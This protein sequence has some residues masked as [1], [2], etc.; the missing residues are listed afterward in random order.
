[1][2]EEGVFSVDTVEIIVNNSYKD[3]TIKIGASLPRALREGLTGM[4][5]KCHDTFTWTL[6]DMTG[7][8]R[9]VIEHHLNIDPSSTP[10]KKSVTWLNKETKLSI[11]KSRH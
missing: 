11:R 1:M 6:V 10:V 4:L 9:S 5:R 3:Q 7:I 8:S 2:E